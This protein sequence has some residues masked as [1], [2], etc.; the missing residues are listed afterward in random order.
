MRGASMRGVLLSCGVAAL[1][2][3]A[4]AEPRGAIA[5]RLPLPAS[6]ADATPLRYLEDARAALRRHRNGEAQEALE[7]AETR[8]LDRGQPHGPDRADNARL[9]Q[10][11]TLARQALAKGDAGRALAALDGVFAPR[12]ATPAAA[13][14][15]PQPTPDGG[16]WVWNGVQWVW[17][18]P[19]GAQYVPPHWEWRFGQWVLVSGEWR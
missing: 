6:G 12:P 9:L 2:G 1:A 5:P 11:T 17:Y 18:P 14:P 15:A 8:M 7:R 10:A 3:V 4:S 19:P 13:P 16:Q